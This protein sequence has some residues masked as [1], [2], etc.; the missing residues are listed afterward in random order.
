MK[1]PRARLLAS[2]AR[3]PAVASAHPLGNFTDQPLQRR[4]SSPA[5]ASMSGT[6]LDLAEIPTFQERRSARRRLRGA[7]SLAACA[8]RVDGRRVDAAA[9][10]RRAVSTDGGAGGLPTLASRPSTGPTVGAAVWSSATRTSRAGSAGGRSSS[11]PSAG[12]RSTARLRLRSASAEPFAPTRRICFASP[13]DVHSATVR[14]PAGAP[15]GIPPALGTPG[16]DADTAHGLRGARQPRS[17]AGIV[18]LSLV[19]AL[20]WGA[21]HA[22]GPGHGKAIVAA[23]LVGTARHRAARR[24]CSDWS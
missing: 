18:L 17:A 13:L 20:F 12:R 11:G 8:S 22:L 1:R 5:T 9:A 21:A 7:A 19:L 16:R 4:S 24:R 2:R 14:L 23:Y 10:R 6:S 15:A 3:A